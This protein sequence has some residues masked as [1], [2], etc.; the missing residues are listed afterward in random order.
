[1]YREE[2][3]TLKLKIGFSDFYNGFDVYNNYW[4]ETL[5]NLYG[6]N[7]VEVVKNP[8]YLF[9]SCFGFEHLKYDCIKIFFTGENIIP[10]FNLC[11][12]AIGFHEICFNDRY[13]R[14]PLYHIYKTA[15]KKAMCRHTYDN[16]FY[17]NRKFCCSVISNSLGNPSRT[18]MLELLNQYK[19]LDN[20]GR[21]KNNIGKCIINKIEF[22]SNYKFVL[23]F[24]NSSTAG[25]TT[26]KLLE[27]FAG[28]GI[29]IYWG[30]PN[31]ENEYNGKAFVNCHRFSSLQEAMNYIRELDKD[32]SKYLSVVKESIFG[33]GGEAGRYEIIQQGIEE[34]LKHIFDQKYVD[35]FRKK[36]SRQEELYIS[37]M[38]QFRIPF[39]ICRI[40][41]RAG[42]FIK[43][44]ASCFLDK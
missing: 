22:E 20:G 19:K 9:Y 4:V 42:S 17:L 40:G 36:D 6:E 32:D 5:K 38:K 24:E 25:Y 8:D 11:D 28:G 34:F 1:M 3:S 33:N 14:M 39:E 18:Q 31:V 23:C 37:R 12:Y 35:A 7:R 16:S 44:R 43:N 27:G 2:K 15:Y 10:D 13:F 30:N 41:Q 29:P 26:E 21:Y